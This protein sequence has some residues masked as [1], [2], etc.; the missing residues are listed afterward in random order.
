MG[1]PLGDEWTLGP[2]GEAAIGTAAGLGDHEVVTVTVAPAAAE[3]AIRRALAKGPDRAVRV[4][5]DRFDG[6]DDPRVTARV[7]A[8]VA[9]D[10]EPDLVVS[11]TRSA[12][13]RVGATAV[14]LATQLDYGWATGVTDAT[15][16]GEAGIVSVRRTLSGRETALLDVTVPAVVTVPAGSTEPQ[17]AG[18]AAVRDAQHAEIDV[19]SLADLGLRP[20]AV[21]SGLTSIDRRERAD[22]VTVLDGPTEATRLAAVLRANGVRQ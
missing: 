11:G 18:L 4:W 20:A 15:L 7:L 8:G 5:D 9:T 16:D 22:E 3:P 14:M 17:Y 12:T 1:P 2:R 19:R 13:D 21:E 6:T 10:I